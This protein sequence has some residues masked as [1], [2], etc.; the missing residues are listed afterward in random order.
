MRKSI[1]QKPEE[2]DRAISAINNQPH[3][4]AKSLYQIWGLKLRKRRLELDLTQTDIAKMFNVTFQQIQ[5]FEN[6]TNR[7]S[8]DKVAMFCQQTG[9]GYGYFLST[10]N[11]RTLITNTGG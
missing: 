7:I 10:L 2:I 5:K 4:T 1:L 9:T 3:F 11:G 8:F 6:G